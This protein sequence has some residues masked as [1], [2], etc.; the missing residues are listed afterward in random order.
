MDW[1]AFQR[2]AVRSHEARWEEDRRLRIQ[3][4]LENL[5]RREVAIQVQ[6]V[7]GEAN[8]PANDD[9]TSWQVLVVP[10]RSST[11]YDVVSLQPDPSS[12]T[13]RVRTP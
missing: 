11:L 12:W 1:L 3:V 13:L 2:I 6:T 7:F 4:E 5:K 8:G 9:A 10:G